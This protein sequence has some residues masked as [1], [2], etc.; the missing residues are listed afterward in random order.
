M[1]QIINQEIADTGKATTQLIPAKVVRQ[2]KDIEEQVHPL[3]IQ[4]L[5]PRT[6][7]P[8]KVNEY[9]CKALTPP[10]YTQYIFDRSG[11][12]IRRVVSDNSGGYN[13]ISQGEK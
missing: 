2:F 9:G 1:Q 13:H 11:A 7:T 8:Q 4:Y 12:T 5:G 6:A 10:F 3:G